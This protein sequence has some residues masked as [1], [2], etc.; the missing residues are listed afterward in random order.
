[1]YKIVSCL[2]ESVI[3]KNLFCPPPHPKNVPTALHCLNVSLSKLLR[4]HDVVFTVIILFDY[5]NIL[6]R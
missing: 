6:K 3:Q 1:M 5:E 4:K 2:Y